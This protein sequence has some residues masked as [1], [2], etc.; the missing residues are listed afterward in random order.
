MNVSERDIILLAITAGEM[1][2]RNGGE[3]Y[4]VEETMA[5]IC[6]AFDVK[7]VEVF[8][9][10]TSIFIS[11][12]K[13]SDSAPYTFQRGI[14]NRD[15][16]LTK[17]SKL[18]HFSRN[19]SPEMI[20][21]EDA[22]AE[23][24]EIDQC[25]SYPYILRFILTGLA[26]A[27]FTMLH[28]GNWN[29][30]FCSLFM[31]FCMS[32]LMSFKYPLQRNG[33]LRT[34]M[35]AAFGAFLALTCFTL[36]L[37]GNFDSVIIGGIMILLPGVAITNAIRDSFSGDLLSGMVRAF[38]AFITSLGIAVGVGIVL[39]IYQTIMIGGGLV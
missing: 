11:L 3:T 30:F 1:M 15:I 28:S 5:R 22:M 34:M 17:V 24:H 25:K 39:A 19:F 10:P 9:T 6:H 23:L 32:A 38:D 33:F 4:R 20:T 2:L 37:S 16:N 31:G 29:D 36:G 13:N 35:G 14:R 27:C 26:T 8:V 12:V 7:Q 18:N 21:I